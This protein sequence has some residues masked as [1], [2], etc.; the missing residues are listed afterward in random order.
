MLKLVL[1]EI[2]FVFLHKTQKI[3]IS[4]ETCHVHIE[5]QGVHANFVFKFF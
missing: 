2:F 3:L 4:H 1:H 5:Y